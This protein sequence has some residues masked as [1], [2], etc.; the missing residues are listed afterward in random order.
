MSGVTAEWTDELWFSCVAKA[1]WNR[2]NRLVGFSTSEV[3]KSVVEIME[4]E[5]TSQKPRQSV[6]SK[7]CF[8]LCSRSKQ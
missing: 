2:L 1:D 4:T 3:S 6:L 8:P 5:S 7:Y